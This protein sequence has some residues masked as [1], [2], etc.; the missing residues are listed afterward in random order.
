MDRC[1]LSSKYKLGLFLSSFKSYRELNE[2]LIKDLE[3]LDMQLN[4]LVPM[5]F[6][7][8]QKNFSPIKLSFVLRK[9]HTLYHDA[10]LWRNRDLTIAYKLRAMLAFGSRSQKKQ[11]RNF[12]GIKQ[13]ENFKI[14]KYIVKGFS[15]KISIIVLQILIKKLFLFQY[16]MNDKQLFDFNLYL[17]LYGGR[18]SAEEDFLLW[19]CDY[20]GID[21][22][23]IQENWDNLSSK[24]ILFQHPDTFVTW[25]PQSTSHLRKLHNYQGE[26]R[27]FGSLRLQQFYR[28]KLIDSSTGFDQTN[29]KNDISASKKMKILLIG[30]GDGTHD[31]DLLKSTLKFIHNYPA[32]LKTNYIFIYRPHPY[33]R[34]RIEDEILLEFRGKILIDT[35][36]LDENNSYRLNVLQNASIVVSLYSTVILEASIL[37][38]VTIIPSF[39]AK[40][41]R[42]STYDYLYES[43]HFKDLQSLVNL[44]NFATETDFFNFL[45]TF[46]GVKADDKRLTC[47]RYCC[48]NLDTSKEISHMLLDKIKVKN[49][50]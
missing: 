44:H 7:V 40:D 50:K 25:G 43:A 12:M 1:Q 35:P 21:S 15:N 8:T 4:I 36:K 23:A 13:S 32:E 16:L 38:K 39:I 20:R 47:V 49:F 2:L 41:Y 26:V 45:L 3:K 42:H 18:T 9:F 30:T 17:F 31:Y 19:V 11:S 28:P 48:S 34:N 33:T 27:E 29:S 10:L 5:N 24:K 46:T 22:I 14:K 6:T 37:N